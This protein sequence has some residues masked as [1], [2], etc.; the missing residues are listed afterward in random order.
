MTE[1]TVSIGI[2]VSKATLDWAAAGGASGSGQVA[3]DPAGHRAL[4]KALQALQPAWVVLE[5]T[6]G[7]ERVAVAALAAAGLPVGVV[8][9][10]QVRDYAKGQGQLAKTDRIDAGILAQFGLGVKP[11]LRPL[12][13]QEERAFR[14]LVDRYGQLVDA[15]VAEQHRLAQAASP[16]VRQSIQ[17]TLT[18]LKKQIKEIEGELD[19]LIQ[20]SPLWKEN[21]DLLQSCKGVGAKTVCMCQ[22]QL[23]ELG[24]VSRQTAAA[25]VGVAPYPHDSGTVR[26]KRRIWGGR[27]A[28]RAVLY[29]ATLTAVRYNPVLKAMYQRLLQRG[30]PKKVALVAC[31][32]KLLTILNA[33]LRDRKPWRESA[34]PA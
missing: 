16:R 8:N 26:G 4:A 5:A 9:P 11:P 23:P 33:M 32:R 34:I 20:K 31:M 6:G 21:Q 25:L 1:S 3:N 10:R 17:Q 30:K 2:D 24:H 15:R 28:V 14:E 22:A 27:A 13:T 19:G 12:A 7:L 29:M 18:F